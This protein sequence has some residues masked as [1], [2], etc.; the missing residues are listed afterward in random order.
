MQE[1]R[2]EIAIENAGLLQPGTKR[3][4]SDKN[5]GEI[6]KSKRVR[7]TDYLDKH[8]KD[9][10]LCAMEVDDMIPKSVSEITT[11]TDGHLW[12]KAMVDELDSL[13]SNNTWTLV[14]KPLG[15][16][17]VG[18]RWVF[19]IK[20]DADG[21]PLRYK[22]RLVAKGFSQIYLEDY[23]ETFAPV[24]RMGSFRF[25]MVFANQHNLHVFCSGRWSQYI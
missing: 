9:Y 14:D 12:E 2:G 16:N 20:Y 4:H 5:V 24:A 15:K 6:R 1:S 23:D 10:L 17:V 8:Y 18:C 21:L 13:R 7:D 11:R 25:M 3:Q 22:A 19:A